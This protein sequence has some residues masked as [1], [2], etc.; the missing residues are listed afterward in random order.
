MS[1]GLTGTKTYFAEILKRG[2]YLHKV[3]NPLSVCVEHF[4]Q[5]L[6]K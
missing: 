5:C 4:W 3:G 6:R 2:S 1:V